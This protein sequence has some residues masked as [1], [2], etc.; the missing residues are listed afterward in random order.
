MFDRLDD[1]LIRY[2]QVMEELN[3]PD[4]V[5]RSD[6]IQKADERTGGSGPDC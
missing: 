5:K 1:I 4:V 3:D 6:K 2:Q